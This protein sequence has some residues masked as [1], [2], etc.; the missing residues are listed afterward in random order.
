MGRPRTSNT[1]TRRQPPQA[2]R[3]D[4]KQP[5]DSAEELEDANRAAAIVT[6]ALYGARK[7]ADRAGPTRGGKR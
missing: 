7:E 6:H 5:Q 4:L 1:G 3:L 2:G